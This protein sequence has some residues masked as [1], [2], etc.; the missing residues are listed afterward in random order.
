MSYSS[1]F[2]GREWEM[3][4]Q[5]MAEGTLKLDDDML[6]RFYPLNEI[7]KAFD[8]YSNNASN[9]KGRIMIRIN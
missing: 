6:Y 9:V 7:R 4:A 1:S 5:C 8:E 3:T 2:P